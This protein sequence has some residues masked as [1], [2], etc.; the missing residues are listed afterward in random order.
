MSVVVSICDELDHHPSSRAPSLADIG[1]ASMLCSRPSLSSHDRCRS[2]CCPLALCAGSGPQPRDR[3]G[4][5]GRRRPGGLLRPAAPS[6]ASGRRARS[7]AL[8]VPDDPSGGE[9]SPARSS[10]VCAA[11]GER[12]GPARAGVSRGG[13]HGSRCASAPAARGRRAPRVGPRAL[14]AV[15]G[16]GAA[17]PRGRP[18]AGA[19]PQHRLRP[20]ASAAAPLGPGAAAVGAAVGRAARVAGRLRG[21]RGA[22]V[23]DLASALHVVH[24]RCRLRCRGRVVGFAGG[25]R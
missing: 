6:G 20:R 13:G 4:R 11:P 5:R 8:A 7:A 2:L 9:Q 19:Q 12:L 10:A 22:V 24:G 21:D 23:G 15:R 18:R 1:R 17:G 16:R 3:R 25:V 14:S